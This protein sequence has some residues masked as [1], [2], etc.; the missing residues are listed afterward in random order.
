M[1]RI[2]QRLKE[3]K[4]VSRMLL[5]VHDELVFELAPSEAKHVSDMV[6]VEMEHAADLSVPLVVDM[7]IGP[8]WLETKSH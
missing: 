5:Q 7:G 2:H 4:L 6:K 1:I 3:E 8:N